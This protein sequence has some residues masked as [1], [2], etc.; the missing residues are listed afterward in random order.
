M[1]ST[2][3][4]VR[5]GFATLAVL[6]VLAAGNIASGVEISIEI[7]GAGAND[8]GPAMEAMVTDALG[9]QT[10]MTLPPGESSLDFRDPGRF[11]IR[12]DIVSEG[13]WAAPTRLRSLDPVPRVEIGVWPTGQVRLPVTAI[14]TQ[15]QKLPLPDVRLL[16]CGCLDTDGDPTKPCGDAHVDVDTENSWYEAAVPVGCR[17]LELISQS[18][19]SITFDQVVIERGRRTQTELSVMSKGGSIRGTVVGYE[20]GRPIRGVEVS[21]RPQFVGCQAVAAGIPTADGQS[22]VIE[23]EPIRTTRTSYRGGFRVSGLEPG[24][25]RLHL[26]GQDL[27]ELNIREIPVAFDSEYELDTIEMGPGAD[28]EVYSTENPCQGE[29]LTASLYLDQGT[30]SMVATQKI[31]FQPPLTSAVFKNMAAGS[32]LLAVLARCGAIEPRVLQATEVEVRPRDHVMVPMDSNLPRIQGRVVR[33]GDPISA[34]VTLT[35]VD[36]KAEATVFNSSLENGFAVT[37]PVVG[38]Y[39]GEI[40][41]VDGQALITVEVAGSDDGYDLVVPACSVEGTVVDRDRDVIAGAIVTA[42]LRSADWV[43]G[44][45]RTVTAQSDAK[46]RFRFDSLAEGEWSFVARVA[47]S[48]SEIRRAQLDEDSSDHPEIELQIEDPT[49]VEVS[50]LSDL[51]KPVANARIAAWWRLPGDDSLV[52]DRKN[53]TTGPDGKVQIAVPAPVDAIRLLVAVDGYSMAAGL[54][55]TSGPI[56]ISVPRDGGFVDLSRSDQPWTHPGFPIAFLRSNGAV[57]EVRETMSSGYGVIDPQSNGSLFRLG[58][59]APGR[60]EFMLVRDAATGAKALGAEA[61]FQPDVAIDVIPNQAVTVDL[62]F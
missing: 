30:G 17:D 28:V 60:Y 20:T 15:R 5:R 61:S 19:S 56:V 57:I 10:L 35:P 53:A 54:F 49:E 21:V 32:Y 62:Q 25:Y 27:A 46:G 41:W 43:I 47:D 45:N 33:G 8:E 6:G 38:D 11:P 7:Y 40:D 34:Q 52:G 29:T 13:W 37:L 12:I 51:A 44:G 58:P 18:F 23:N 59:L 14:D 36:G 4:Q 50:L 42:R 48:T 55:P 3:G 39:A 9:Q 2:R 22:V 24:D 16:F 1:G 26:L 31:E